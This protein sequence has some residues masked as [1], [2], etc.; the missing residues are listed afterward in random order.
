MTGWSSPV[1]IG[2]VDG[3]TSMQV[4]SGGSAAGTGVVAWTSA[5]RISAAAHSSSGWSSPVTVSSAAE[6]AW[7]PAV[8]VRPDGSAQL[9]WAAQRNGIAVIESASRSTLGS[10][11]SPVVVSAAGLLSAGPVSTAMDGS[12]AVLAVWA[13]SSSTRQLTVTSAVLVPGRAWSTPTTVAAPVASAIRQVVVSENRSGTAVIGWVRQAGDL[14]GDV[15]SRSASGVLGGPVTIAT[16]G[17]RPLQNQI[18]FFRLAIDGNGR[19]SAAW[20]TTLAWAGVARVN[21]SWAVTSFAHTGVVGSIDLAVDASGNAQLLWSDSGQLMASTLP[22]S[23]SWTAPTAVLTG[24]TPMD[25]VVTTSGA[26]AAAAWFDTST[27]SITAATYTAGGWGSAA[28][29]SYL[30]TAAWIAGVSA[31]PVANGTLVVWISGT[32]GAGTVRASLSSG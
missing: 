31:A 17:L 9:V 5:G 8:S 16:G 26:N 28:S 21:G 15:V 30:G 20:N 18:H 32:S 12:G 25:L 13:Q 11:T 1:T 19:A 2:S 6:N 10:W 4:A 29:L 3:T 23:G 14:Y 7:S 27:R 24:S 22:A